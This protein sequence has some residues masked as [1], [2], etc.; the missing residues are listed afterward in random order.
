MLQHNV[1]NMKKRDNKFLKEK[2]R[3]S[4][5]EIKV[6]AKRPKKP[7]TPESKRA[8]DFFASI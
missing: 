8:D 5:V 2:Q 6:K 1:D 7:N 4:N 3:H